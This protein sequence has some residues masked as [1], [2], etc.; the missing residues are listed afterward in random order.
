MDCSRATG[1]PLNI[2]V[3]GWPFRIRP[4][5]TAF[6]PSAAGSLASFGYVGSSIGVSSTMTATSTR[7]G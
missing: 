6:V 3:E 7:M 1:S 2:I 4:T 5:F